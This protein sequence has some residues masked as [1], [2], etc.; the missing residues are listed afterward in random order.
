MFAMRVLHDGHLDSTA[1]V[2]VQLYGSLG[3]TGKGHGSDK[4]VLL[5]LAGHEP[6]TVDVGAIP[7]LLAEVRSQGRLV[8]LSRHEIV[9]DEKAD[10]TFHR[11]ESLPF[12]ANGMRF[13]AFDAGGHELADRCYYSVGGGF[14][15][16]DEVAADGGRQKVI[17][18]DA[19]VLPYP[20]RTGDELL[21]LTVG[22]GCSIAELMRRNATT[23]RKLATSVLRD[24]AE[25]EDA[26][27]EHQGRALAGVHVVQVV[28]VQPS[29]CR[30]Q[31]WHG[32]TSSYVRPAGRPVGGTRP[33]Y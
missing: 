24:V 8:L 31:R 25:A 2:W 15:V 5:G 17:A 32:R 19:T 10:L 11:R 7:T 12:H 20:F 26:V 3:A 6:D 13:I 23:T 21:A 4:A 18:P 33:C 16:S 29:P 27:Q 9:F 22:T 28:A 1:R 30:R 14:V